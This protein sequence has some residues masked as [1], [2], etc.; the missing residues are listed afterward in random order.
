[1][2][3]S[4]Y[5]WNPL[6]ESAA[7]TIVGAIS[8]YAF[9]E[10]L[11]RAC[12]RNTF[13]GPMDLWHRGIM[14]SSVG[15]GDCVYLDCQLSPYSQL[16][17]GNPFD[18]TGR[19]NTLYDFDGSITKN[20]YQAMEFYAGS[21]AALRIGSING[22]TI[23]GL[24]HRY[25][26]IGD[27][28]VGIAPTTMM[29]K[30]LAAFFNPKFSG[31]RAL[32]K[33]KLARCPSQHG[34]AAQAIA[35]RAGLKVNVDYKQLWYLQISSFKLF[36]RSHQSTVTLLGSPWAVTESKRNQY[37]IQYGYIS[38]QTERQTCVNKITEAS[39]WSSARVYFDDIEAPSKELSFKHNYI[40]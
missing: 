27:G 29:K 12:A 23:I 40:A 8:G 31:V 5:L 10:I 21:D 24:Y 28:L 37:L 38:N 6:L 2:P 7:Q 11:E 1:M 22:E 35:A 4:E 32:V 26:F 20:E 13:D 34:F 17:P 39:S 33:G 18:N 25:G 30:R 3:L 16:F 9:K 15:D 19:W 36:N 14:T